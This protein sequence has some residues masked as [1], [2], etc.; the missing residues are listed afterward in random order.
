MSFNCLQ[1]CIISDKGLHNY[2]KICLFA[3]KVSVSHAAFLK[4]GLKI[5]RMVLNLQNYCKDGTE[6][7]YTPIP[8]VS[9]LSLS[10]L[11][12]VNLS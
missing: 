4:I 1:V 11:S 5:F 2:I 9:L 10:C 3:C 8:C 12:V 7:S 6:S